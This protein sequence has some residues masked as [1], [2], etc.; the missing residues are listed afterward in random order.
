MKADKQLLEDL[1]EALEG[2]IGVSGGWPGCF[3]VYAEPDPTYCPLDRTLRAILQ[4][5]Y[6]WCERW[7][8]DP[9]HSCLRSRGDKRWYSVS[10]LQYHLLNLLD[11]LV[12]EEEQCTSM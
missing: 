3:S 4:A 7:L 5:L 2:H 10:G 8:Q 9:A 12:R 11:E 1:V 6:M